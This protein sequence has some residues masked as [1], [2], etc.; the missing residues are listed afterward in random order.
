M[1][2]RG[3]RAN[4]N[5]VFA[6]VDSQGL[7]WYVLRI[8]NA[9]R[10]GFGVF[11]QT[12][13]TIAS[14]LIWL[15]ALAGQA[16][17]IVQRPVR[18]RAGELVTVVPDGDGREWICTVMHWVE[19]IVPDSEFAQS[20][21]FVRKLAGLTARLHGCAAGWIAPPGFVRPEYDGKRLRMY[22]ERIL[23][24]VPLGLYPATVVPAFQ[25]ACDK[26]AGLLEEN[27]VR[28]G[29]WML[30]HADLKADNCLVTGDGR[31]C[32]I[33]FA[34]CGYGPRALDIAGTMTGLPRDLRRL[35]LEAY[36]G[37]RALPEKWIPLYGACAL[38]SVF[39]YCAF[40]MPS[41]DRHDWLR[42][43]IPQ[44]AEEYCGGFLAGVTPDDWLR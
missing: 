41:A 15:E 40:V 16:D 28:P 33:D 21:E 32:P 3:L 26:A 20:R 35:Y 38:F 14:E 6:L 19:G 18:N 34:L 8:H 22:V 9:G 2:R 17:L 4:Q 29:E 37:H 25:A 13:E 42:R 31:L 11:A 36:S 5:A 23:E 12:P 27:K 7:P 24:G 39:S 43:R 44:I 10:P 1:E 30:I